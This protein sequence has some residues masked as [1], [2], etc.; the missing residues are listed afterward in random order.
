MKISLSPSSLLIITILCLSLTTGCS[1]T[2]TRR[3]S[4]DSLNK[5]DRIDRIKKSTVRIYANG[6]PS[7]TGFI[8]DENGLIATAFHVVGKTEPTSG[9]RS[10]ITYAPAIEVEFYD[11]E[12]LPAIPHKTFI[13]QGIYE[14]V[15]KDYC[16]LE[17][18]TAKKL[19]PLRLGYFYDAQ[20][21]TEVYMCG[22]SLLS[23]QPAVSFGVVTAR[24][25]DSVLTY[26]GPSSYKKRN[27][28][29]IAW[30][31]ISMTRGNSG[32]P[33]VLMGNNPEQDRVIG[34]ASFIT[35]PLDQDIKAL[36]KALKGNEPESHYAPVCSIELFCLMKETLGPDSLFIK[37]CVS[38]DSL[39][40]RLQKIVSSQKT[41]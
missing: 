17:V 36:I 7:G 11:G 5:Q 24:W 10:F 33:I 3:A 19:I 27:I 22:Y 1:Q 12:K 32:G 6:K 29:G 38:I 16:I 8:I 37:G 18:K 9:K 39:R 30:L 20:E 31:D 15:S 34:I 4:S 40:M 13:G 21:G 14:A 28:I 41:A 25:K 23:E 2:R 35:T 26:H